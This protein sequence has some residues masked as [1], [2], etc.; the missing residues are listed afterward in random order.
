MAR[1]ANPK[2]IGVF[3][4]GAIV[5][6]VAGILAFGS[7]DYFAPKGKAVLLFQG[8]LA[9]LDVGSPVTF[10][11]VRVGSVTNIV[12]Q[13]NVIEQ[14]LFIPVFI[15]LNPQK[16]EIVRGA[17]SEHNIRD[18]V[19]RGLRAQLQVQSLVTGQTSVDFDFYPDTPVKLTDIDLGVPQLPTIPS[20]I[21]L[22]KANVTSLL[23]KINNLPLE[24]L[25]DQ[26]LKVADNAN[27]VLTETGGV[28]KS[29]GGLVSDVQAQVKPLIDS[30]LATSDQAS[31]LMQE[32]RQRL[33]LREGEPLQ[34][35]NL[36][37]ADARKML[38]VLNRDLPQ[39][40]GPAVQTLS[41][42]SAALNQTQALIQAAQRL[43]SPGSPVYFEL[44]ST[45]TEFKSAAR[46]IRV[47]AEYIQRNPNALLTGNNR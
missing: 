22:L 45:L 8:S 43:I 42:T 24:Q 4:L 12:I 9:G 17:R 2:L 44:T 34:N 13:Y 29:A 11:G 27:Q 3:V 33:Q 30:V 39:I 35:L 5:L 23:A 14:K 32:A 21:D 25:S 19:E 28:V 26:L 6:L 46:A 15:E 38:N 47:F 41:K 7:G 31:L 1:K 16:F 10:R 40:L 20:S 36:T 37:L 18:L